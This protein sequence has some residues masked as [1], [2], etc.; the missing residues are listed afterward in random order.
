MV[1]IQKNKKIRLKI[2]DKIKNV[3]K[4]FEQ[5]FHRKITYK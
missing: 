1:K 2:K 4:I 5:A 3:R